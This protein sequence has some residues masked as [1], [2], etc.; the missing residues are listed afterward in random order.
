MC[1]SLHISIILILDKDKA[2]LRDRL[3]SSVCHESIRKLLDVKISILVVTYRYTVTGIRLHMMPENTMELS[4]S[5]IFITVRTGDETFGE[6]FSLNYFAQ[7]CSKNY[8]RLS[9]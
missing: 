8:L 9:L 7:N 4:Q 3:N 6:K 5:D 2:L 1:C